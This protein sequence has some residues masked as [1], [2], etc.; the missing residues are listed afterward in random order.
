MGFSRN[1]LHQLI[2][3]RLSLLCVGLDIDLNKI[4]KKLVDRPFEFNKSIIDATRPYCI[5]YKINFAF[6]ESLGVAGWELLKATVDYIGEDHFIIA[7]AKRGD[8]G[9]TAEMYSAAVYDALPCDA[10]TVNPYMGKDNVSPFLRDGKF[11]I[12]LAL[13]SNKGSNDFQ[14]LKLDSGLYLYEQVMETV[15]TWSDADH[16][17]FVLGATHPSDVENCRK[18]YPDHFFL[19]PGVGAQGGDLEAICRAGLNHQGGLLINSSRSIIYASQGDDFSE[20][21]GEEAKKLQEEMAIL[22][23]ANKVIQ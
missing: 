15:T 21:A 11:A 7:D 8:I 3:S 18:K 17:M 14:R 23:K 13:T 12:V 6:Y 5:G 20:R 16:I 9:N 2:S 10:V 19:V 1:K 4:P 22:L